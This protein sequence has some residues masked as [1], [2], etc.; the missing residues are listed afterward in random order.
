MTGA[1]SGNKSLMPTAESMYDASMPGWSTID[2]IL[3]GQGVR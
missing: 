3:A 2:T 1:S